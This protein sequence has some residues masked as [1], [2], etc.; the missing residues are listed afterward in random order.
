MEH[1]PAAVRGERLQGHCRHCGAPCNGEPP[2]I[3]CLT[4][5]G[6]L[7]GR[8]ALWPLLGA[9]PRLAVPPGC[10]GVL[11]PPHCERPVQ[12]PPCPFSQPGGGAQGPRE[13]PR[14]PPAQAA[15]RPPGPPGAVA[16]DGQL[17]WARQ[18]ARCR[19]GKGGR[20]SGRPQ[21]QAGEGG[22]TRPLQRET[23]GISETS[24]TQAPLCAAT[25]D[26]S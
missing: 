18:S 24:P 3:A 5:H 2:A 25:S 20:I 1:A 19:G 15:H 13:Q 7:D 23:A 12:R 17:H 14:Q 6:I 21:G 22:R 4:L 11:L 26:Q 10:R 16:L 8:H 9:P